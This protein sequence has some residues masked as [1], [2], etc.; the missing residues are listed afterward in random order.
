MIDSVGIRAVWPI[1]FQRVSIAQ[2]HTLVG[3]VVHHQIHAGKV[4]SGAIQLLTIEMHMLVGGY[5]AAVGVLQLLTY[6][7]KQRTRSAGWI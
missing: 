2:V 3:H 7:K 5:G 1:L 6:R 4:V